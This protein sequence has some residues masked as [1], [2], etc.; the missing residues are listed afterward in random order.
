MKLH[1]NRKPGASDYINAVYVNVSIIVQIGHYMGG[2][3][4]IHIWAWSASPPV[5]VGRLYKSRTQAAKSADTF[6]VRFQLPVF[7]QSTE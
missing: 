6:A 4:N 1:E 2:T 7:F 3:F 5:Q